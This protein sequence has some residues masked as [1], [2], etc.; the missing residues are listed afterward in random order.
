MI[1]NNN[2]AKLSL[3]PSLLASPSIMCKIL[4]SKN[5]LFFKLPQRENWDGKRDGK[6]KDQT[7]K[8]Q[9]FLCGYIHSLSSSV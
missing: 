7:H 4:Q 6:R 1:W 9:A 5:P 8:R 3:S 2:L